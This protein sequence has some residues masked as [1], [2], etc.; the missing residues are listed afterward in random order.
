[1]TVT[2]T[3][4]PQSNKLLLSTFQTIEIVDMSSVV[5]IA[6]YEN[7]C[8]IYTENGEQYLSTSSFGS[9][10]LKLTG[11]S[12]FHCHKSYAVSLRHIKRVHKSGDIELTTGAKVPLA[13]RRKELF[14][15]RLSEWCE[16]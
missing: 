1:M 10:M 12:F 16:L 2:A 14:Y 11:S 3:P 4:L 9:T 7:Y 6:A 8:K 5:H 13:R 15:N